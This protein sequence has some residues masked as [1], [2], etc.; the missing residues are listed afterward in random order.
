[1][2]NIKMN[3]NYKNIMDKLEELSKLDKGKHK[4]VL[5]DSEEPI[6]LSKVI[7]ESS[8]EPIGLKDVREK[9]EQQ[10]KKFTEKDIELNEEMDYY[11]KKLQTEIE[12][13]TPKASSSSLPDIIPNIINPFN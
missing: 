2:I 7:A 12:D 13:N 11:F 5:F 10:N 3:L 6:T 8:N 4:E 1:M 9:M